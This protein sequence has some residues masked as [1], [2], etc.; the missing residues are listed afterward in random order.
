MVV[1][2]LCNH[3]LDEASVPYEM[4]DVRLEY[5]SRAVDEDYY[6]K[7]TSAFRELTCFVYVR[8][9]PLI[10]DRLLKWC[11]EY[12]E[13][14]PWRFIVLEGTDT[15]Y[16]FSE[17]RDR[18]VYTFYQPEQH[19]HSTTTTYF[20][21]RIGNHLQSRGQDEDVSATHIAEGTH[22]N[23]P[24]DASQY[25]TVLRQQFAADSIV[26]RTPPEGTG[27]IAQWTEQMDARL[28]T[29]A[30]LIYLVSAPGAGKTYY[31]EN[32]VRTRMLHQHKHYKRV[33]CSSDEL[34]ERSLTHLLE[35]SFPHSE[36]GLLV[37]D[38]FHM[39]SLSMKQELMDWV[40]ARHSFL[41]VVLV[42]NRTVDDDHHLLEQFRTSSVKSGAQVF[43]VHARLTVAKLLQFHK[44]LY[45]HHT[46]CRILVGRLCRCLRHLFGDEALSY[47]IVAPLHDAIQPGADRTALVDLMLAKIPMVGPYTA[48]R[49]VHIMKYC[50]LATGEG[51]ESPLQLLM[52]A[53]LLDEEERS[54]PYPEFARRL[55]DAH[56]AHPILRLMAW[57]TYVCSVVN[58]P[59][60]GLG[61]LR[62]LQVI[63]Q[64]GFP[65]VLGEA[66][67]CSLGSCVAF[68]HHGDYNDLVW[69]INAVQ[70]GK[71]LDWDKVGSEWRCPHA[72]FSILPV[73]RCTTI[74][75]QNACRATIIAILLPSCV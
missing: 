30:V 2:P 5:N 42:A 15:T 35:E 70:H 8:G 16:N 22:Q 10:N 71:A 51:V 36:P 49:F 33:D 40:A 34:L 4:C 31:L 37:A 57:V 63:D 69:M 21:S 13:R 24:L 12:T 43:Q 14:I 48:G 54:C 41:S 29:G 58:R 1:D 52:W 7:I 6:S 11:C 55:T 25:G 62:R 74:C 72:P 56:R 38:E 46:E 20:A 27:T 59:T 61:V 47:R 39:L 44:T 28:K 3:R 64:I 17:N 66:D 65:R 23:T 73:Y 53:A 26:F 18:C 50:D 9:M 19:Q 68:C 75:S 60:P 67:E 32:I 45:P